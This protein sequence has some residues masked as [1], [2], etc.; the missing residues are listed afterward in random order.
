MEDRNIL[1]CT[2]KALLRDLRKE[3]FILHH[4]KKEKKHLTLR[5]GRSCEKIKEI[6]GRIDYNMNKHGKLLNDV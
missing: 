2:L 1:I 3:K 4:I 6:R 5:E